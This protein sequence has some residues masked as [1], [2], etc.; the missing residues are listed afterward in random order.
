MRFLLLLLT[1][2]STKLSIISGLPDD[3]ND[4]ETLFEEWLLK[5]DREYSS[6]D[7]RAKKMSIWIDNH[8][9]LSLLAEWKKS[10]IRID[11]Q[12]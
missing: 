1:A 9:M 4:F 2:F 8:G 10:L 3:G 7:E 12:L 5:F 6:A 11:D